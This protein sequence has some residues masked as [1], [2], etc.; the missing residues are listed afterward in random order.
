M[1]FHLNP[2]FRRQ[3]GL[4]RQTIICI[5]VVVVLAVIFIFSIRKSG[6]TARP[7]VT[8]DGNHFIVKG[9][10][11]K[12]LSGSIHYFRVV[13]DYWEDRMMKLKAMGLNT[14]ETLVLWWCGTTY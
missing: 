5:A 14:V 3:I 13:P 7:S 11:T 6:F 8:F 1:A 10:K 4:N 2:N 9:R 12:I